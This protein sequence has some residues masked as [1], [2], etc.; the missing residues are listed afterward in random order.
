MFPWLNSSGN[1][2]LFGFRHSPCPVFL[3]SQ[4]HHLEVPG[5]NFLVCF[6]RSIILPLAWKHSSDPPCRVEQKGQVFLQAG[7][8]Y[9]EAAQRG[10][11]CPSLSRPALERVLF[12]EGGLGN[13]LSHWRRQIGGCL[14]KPCNPSLWG[15]P[16]LVQEAASTTGPISSTTVCRRRTL[17]LNVCAGNKRCPEKDRFNFFLLPCRGA[18][19]VGGFRASLPLAAEMQHVVL[20]GSSRAAL[21]RS[22][23]QRAPRRWVE[24]RELADAEAVCAL[25]IGRTNESLKNN[26]FRRPAQ[27]QGSSSVLCWQLAASPQRC[28]KSESS[29]NILCCSRIPALSPAAGRHAALSPSAPAVPSPVISSHHRAN[30]GL[31]FCLQE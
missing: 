26:S 18:V 22:R 10:Q 3:P 28:W 15:S 25:R 21:S 11:P 31:F 20:R 5:L 6:C 8:L 23:W 19:A 17:I 4:R 2:G 30:Q 24:G 13:M 29:L 16:V 9:Q 12:W 14:S 1:W 7:A 27:C